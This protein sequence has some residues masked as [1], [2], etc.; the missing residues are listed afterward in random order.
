MFLTLARTGIRLGECLG[1]QW[2]DI[3]FENRFINIQRGFSKGK[4]ETPKS[5]QSRKVDMSL[6]LTDGLKKILRQRKIDTLERGWGSVPEWVFVRNNGEPYHESYLRRLFY[7][8]I[9]KAGLRKIRI[10]YFFGF[11]RSK[12]SSRGE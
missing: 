12:T 4:I 2:K 1:L 6:Q 5:G 8:V 9:E 10:Q 3:D 7:K 11:A